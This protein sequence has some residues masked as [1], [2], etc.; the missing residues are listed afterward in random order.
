[1]AFFQINT[2]SKKGQHRSEVAVVRT[3]HLGK[4]IKNKK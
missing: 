2:S 4:K 3:H 1:M